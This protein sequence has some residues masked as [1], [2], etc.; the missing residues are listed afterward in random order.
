MLKDLIKIADKLD[1]IGLTK[2]AD[3]IDQI[4]EKMAIAQSAVRTHKV[5]SGETFSQIVATWGDPLKT[6]KEQV[7][8]NKSKNPNFNADKLA[9]GQTVYL[10]SP[11]EGGDTT[12]PPE[13]L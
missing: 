1:K 7:D 4:I 13:E 12:A 2:E 9:V 11:P 5:T 3:V 10:Y 6:F 8:L